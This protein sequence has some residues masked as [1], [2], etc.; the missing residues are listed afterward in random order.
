MSSL[1]YSHKPLGLDGFP[2]YS[3]KCR[4]HTRVKTLKH[5]I[6]PFRPEVIGIRCMYHTTLGYVPDP[7][8]HTLYKVVPDPKWYTLYEVVPDTQE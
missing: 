8:W 4:G 6:Q 5:V 2:P 3:T 7:E 1:I